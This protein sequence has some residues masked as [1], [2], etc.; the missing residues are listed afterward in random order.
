M[1]SRLAASDGPTSGD[2]FAQNTGKGFTIKY[3]PEGVTATGLVIYIGRVFISN[4]SVQGAVTELVAAT[5]EFVFSGN[6]CSSDAT[7][8]ALRRSTISS[9]TNNTTTGLGVA[10]AASF[11]HAA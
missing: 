5:V 6:P 11:T 10:A 7:D 8:L 2:T 3:M 4:Y 9:L 1:L